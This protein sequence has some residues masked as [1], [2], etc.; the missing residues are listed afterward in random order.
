MTA[1]NMATYIAPLAQTGGLHTVAMDFQQQV[2]YIAN[3]AYPLIHGMNSSDAAFNRQFVRLN[4]G[5]LFKE[6]PPVF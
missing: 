3:A 4:M 5:P 6:G 2:L 1:L